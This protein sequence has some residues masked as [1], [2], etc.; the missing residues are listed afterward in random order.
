MFPELGQSVQNATW[1]I[2][3]RQMLAELRDIQG[4]SD[5]GQKADHALPFILRQKSR[6]IRVSGVES[7]T[8]SDGF[9]VPQLVLGEL[10][11]LVRRPVAVIERSGG[12]ELERIAAL[13]NM[14]N[15]EIGAPIDQLLHAGHVASG[16]RGRMLLEKFE[17]G[18]VLD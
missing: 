5:R 4:K 10:L 6:Q 15:V 18:G 16:Q 7:D 14:L 11:Q 2:W 17:E 8:D 13:R 3:L 9:T 12:A 1:I